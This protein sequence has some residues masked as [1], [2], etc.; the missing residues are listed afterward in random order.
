MFPF[1]K[2]IL[3]TERIVRFSVEFKMKHFYQGLFG[4]VVGS[5]LY[6]KIISGVYGLQ[7]FHAGF[8]AYT[9]PWAVNIA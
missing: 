5:V 3:Q 9:G 8:L 2:G 6:I 4:W 1:H 7:T